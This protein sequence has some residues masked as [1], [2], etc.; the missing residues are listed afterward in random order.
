MER[1]EEFSDCRQ[2]YAKKV[3]VLEVF[4]GLVREG[5]GTLDVEM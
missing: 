3:E 5:K 4:D 2:V 1:C